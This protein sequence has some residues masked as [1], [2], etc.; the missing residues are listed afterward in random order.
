MFPSA[1]GC[2]ASLQESS[3]SPL[4]RAHHAHRSGL[5]TFTLTRPAAGAEL[6][7]LLRHFTL[8]AVTAHLPQLSSSSLGSRGATG[9]WAHPEGERVRGLVPASIAALMMD[10]YAFVG[11]GHRIG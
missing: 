1:A 3:L 11:V 8:H 7:S 5:Q 9:R 4:L 6:Q 10:F 2:F